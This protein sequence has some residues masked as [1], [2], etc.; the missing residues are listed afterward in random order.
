[1]EN[2]NKT[3]SF[4]T[5]ISNINSLNQ[6]FGMFHRENIIQSA[7]VQFSVQQLEEVIY[8]DMVTTKQLKNQSYQ[9]KVQYIEGIDTE[10]QIKVTINDGE[11]NKLAKYLSL[12]HVEEL[13]YKA[14]VNSKELSSTAYNM[15]LD[16]KL[17]PHDD[18]GLIESVEVTAYLA[19][20][21][22]K[23]KMK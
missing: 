16:F 15:K 1:M 20:K 13:L 21:Q 11:E 4:A 6:V 7:Q 18:S 3:A 17:S 8:K 9:L 12:V 10:G 22:K 5:M 19:E 14:M 2:K 23:I